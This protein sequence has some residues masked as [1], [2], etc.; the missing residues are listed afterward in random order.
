M[1]EKSGQQAGPRVNWVVA[2]TSWDGVKRGPL[3]WGLPTRRGRGGITVAGVTHPTEHLA[4]PIPA[5]PP[6]APLER[7]EN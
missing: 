1:Q 5:P 2:G 4:G 6:P 3:P 7:W